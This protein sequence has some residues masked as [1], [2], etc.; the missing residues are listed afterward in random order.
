MWRT[1]QRVVPFGAD[2]PLWQR[3][4][5]GVISEFTNTAAIWT[6]PGRGQAHVTFYGKD[7]GPEIARYLR[8]VLFRVCAAEQRRFKDLDHYRL[9]SRRA[10]ALEA[11]T[12]G[13]GH[14][15]TMR[16]MAL[17]AS[18][19]NSA[20]RQKARDVA[21]RSTP[22][23]KDKERRFRKSGNTS[24]PTYVKATRRQ[25]I[26]GAKKRRASRPQERK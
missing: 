12:Q 26:T 24:L 4:L 21:A 13:L 25:L 16:L 1:G 3:S 10:K 8:D 11:F 22:D 5:L 2:I 20:D 19:I 9:R 14:R 15:L 7:F 6:Q 18:S 17:F 23:V